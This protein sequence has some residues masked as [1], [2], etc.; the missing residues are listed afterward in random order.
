MH[1]LFRKK[2]NLSIFC[3]LLL[4]L[5]LANN[6]LSQAQ[7]NLQNHDRRKIHFGISLGTNLSRF[8][9]THSPD[10]AFHDTIKSV[11]SSRSGGFNVG[12]ISD[13]HMGKRTD[14]RFIPS[15]VFAE[16]KLDYIEL[17]P[18]GG[19]NLATNKTIESIMLTFPLSVKYKSDRFFDNFR[20][21]VIG[22]GRL[23]WDLASN[24]KA[25]KA[26][27]IVKIK[28]VDFAVEYGLGLEFYFPLFIFS[29][30]IRFSNGLNNI[31]TD[32][33][34]LRYSEV[35]GRLKSRAVMITL[36]FEG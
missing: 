29:P 33:P 12:I 30:E 2:T 7:P 9:V 22:G 16:K 11:Q 23:D 27:D 35:L 1:H 6:Q 19:P 15:L 20:F 24:S 25:R 21:Y 14:L 34:N 28:P 10:F 4:S 8:A 17:S 26:L 5:F 31:F 3:A 32:T 13:F 36:Q 18:D